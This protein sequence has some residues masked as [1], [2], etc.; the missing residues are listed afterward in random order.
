[1]PVV[2]F[3]TVQAMRVA[4]ASALSL[5]AGKTLVLDGDAVFA[6]ANEAGITIV[7]RERN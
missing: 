1:V 4:G 7:G 3:A 5:D 2:G 6:A